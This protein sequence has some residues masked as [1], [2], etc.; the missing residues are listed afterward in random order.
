[1]KTI[2]KI[3][4]LVTLF[5][6]TAISQFGI[7]GKPFSEKM[8]NTENSSWKM[9]LRNQQKEFYEEEF[10]AKDSRIIINKTI[11][12]DGFLLIENIFQIWDGFAWVDS[13]KTSNTYNINNNIIEELMQTWDGS[14][15]VGIDILT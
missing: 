9:E 5:S 10:Y 12:G 4:C 13:I 1:M 6:I 11:L 8:F 2:M 7:D 3:L 14:N 15:W